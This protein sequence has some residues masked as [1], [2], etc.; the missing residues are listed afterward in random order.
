MHFQI[1]SV[2]NDQIITEYCISDGLTDTTANTVLAAATAWK[3]TVDSSKLEQ[4]LVTVLTQGIPD[5]GL[6][7]AIKLVDGLDNFK[8]TFCDGGPYCTMENV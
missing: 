4:W 8:V 7:R 6:D 2:I 5:Y 3:P 1:R